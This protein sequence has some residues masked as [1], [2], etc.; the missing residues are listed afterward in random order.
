MHER[1]HTLKFVVMWLSL[2]VFVPGPLRAQTPETRGLTPQEAANILECDWLFQAM[3]EPLLPRTGREIDW[4][5]GLAERLASA[6]RAPD[7][8]AELARLETLERKS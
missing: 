6:D 7:L 1:R 3:G 8:S 5:R 2:V 4:A